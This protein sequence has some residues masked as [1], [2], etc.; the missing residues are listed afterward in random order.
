MLLVHGSDKI[1]FLLGYENGKNEIDEWWT[2]LVSDHV[3]S[4]SMRGVVCNG[5]NDFGVKRSPSVGTAIQFCHTSHPWSL[6]REG[7]WGGRFD[8][9]SPSPHVLTADTGIGW[10]AWR[11]RHAAGTVGR[12]L[13]TASGGVRT[14]LRR[15]PDSA[16]PLSLC[17]WHWSLGRGLYC[18]YDQYCFTICLGGS[19]VFLCF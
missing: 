12:W 16:W 19:L 18:E 2:E 9:S 17:R 4:A 15:H 5:M 11:G 6:R 13:W 7:G 8:P 14:C 3:L 1:T 10:G